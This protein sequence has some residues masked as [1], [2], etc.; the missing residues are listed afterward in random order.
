MHLQFRDHIS[1]GR[2]R[3]V[4]ENKDATNLCAAVGSAR[5]SVD[6]AGCIKCETFLHAAAVEVV[7]CLSAHP[8][9]VPVPKLDGRVTTRRRQQERF[10]WVNSQRS[11]RFA[12]VSLQLLDGGGLLRRICIR[13]SS[14]GVDKDPP[15][16]KPG[17]KPMLSDKFGR[18]NDTAGISSVNK[19]GQPL[20]Y[21]SADD[22][23]RHS[24]L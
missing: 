21:F 24:F 10:G 3:I 13:G 15:V 5:R 4:S 2:I 22:L 14:V 7:K 23:Q 8:V 18:T 1:L 9:L 16:L 20:R 11:D 6:V 17:C 12:G 19:Q